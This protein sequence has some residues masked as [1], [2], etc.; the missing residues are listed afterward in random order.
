MK[1]SRARTWL[2]RTAI[3]F[4]MVLD[5]RSARPGGTRGSDAR[6]P[7]LGSVISMRPTAAEEWTTSLVV[8]SCSLVPPKPD[9]NVARLW[10]S[11]KGNGATKHGALR[12]WEWMG[13]THMVAAFRHIGAGPVADVSRRS[14]VH[15][16]L[17]CPRAPVSK[18]CWRPLWGV[19]K[20][21]CPFGP[22]GSICASTAM[23]A[24]W[25]WREPAEGGREFRVRAA[26]GNACV[27]RGLML[28]VGDRLLAW[29]ASRR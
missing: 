21:L 7:A 26:V 18:P 22:V 11:T 13:L 17:R 27:S 4:E 1:S 2:A 29:S 5:W 14:P 9:A 10:G 25:M 15:P 23:A 19:V 16:S 20:T 3:C 12:S 28:C 24:F 8:S 6:R